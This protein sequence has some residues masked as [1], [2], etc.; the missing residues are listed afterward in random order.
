M[1]RAGYTCGP[2]TGAR[3]SAAGRRRYAATAVLG[4]APVLPVREVDG[5]RPLAEHE[6]L[7][8][9]L[10]RHRG[11]EVR[12][13]SPVGDRLRRLSPSSPHRRANDDPVAQRATGPIVPP[14]EMRRRDRERGAR[15]VP[16][17][18]GKRSA[19]EPRRGAAGVLARCAAEPSR[20]DRYPAAAGRLS[21]GLADA[22]QPGEPFARSS[23][24]TGAGR[25][26]RGRTIGAC[27]ARR[28]GHGV[29][30]PSLLGSSDQ[31]PAR[32]VRASVRNVASPRRPLLLVL[33]YGAFLALVGITAT[34]QAVMVSAHFS[35]ATLNDVV[36][37][38]AATTRAF[39]NAHVRPR[40]LRRGRAV[41][42]PRGRARGAARHADA[43]G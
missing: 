30:G 7:R 8:L 25:P 29:D 28:S 26:M 40:G 20:L 1:R 6:E 18:L 16:S 17:T 41:R 22:L 5:R 42:R 12:Q 43:H 21:Q 10:D 2:A 35:T 39:V 3:T 19:T 32:D 37:S 11:L 27:A 14:G 13:P 9:P 36:G 24:A 33:V 31:P 15:T 34:A 38:D 23:A 4:V